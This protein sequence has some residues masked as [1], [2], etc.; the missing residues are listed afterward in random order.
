MI[1]YINTAMAEMEVALFDESALYFYDKRKAKDEALELAQILSD[2]DLK[3]LE[4]V[5]VA[6]GPG[7]FTSL[8]VGI[9]TAQTLA[10][11]KKIPM[12][13]FVTHDYLKSFVK[14]GV[15]TVQQVAVGEVFLNGELK[16]FEELSQE[17]IQWIGEV[18]TP[19]FLPEAWE[20]IDVE[21]KSDLNFFLGFLKKLKPVDNVSVYY[22]KE[23]N[24]FVS[25]K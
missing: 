14:D 18:R 16:K 11:T 12:Y 9:A 19:Q 25:K 1:L 2:L 8:R 4:G 21:M 15:V 7:R 13:P 17:G 5:M 23:P 20:S 24:I 22:G 3:N 6:K 10:Y